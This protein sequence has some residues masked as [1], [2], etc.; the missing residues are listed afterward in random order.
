M[1]E[2]Q[3]KGV[4][5]LADAIGALRDELIRAWSSSQQQRLRFKPSPVQLTV[6]V[7]VTSAGKGRAGVRW[8]LVELGGEVSR[9]TVTTQTL[10][11]SLDPVMYDDQGRPHD[12]LISDVD[13]EADQLGEDDLLRDPE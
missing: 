9:E 8:W 6:Q 4:V 11:L 12:V 5:G 13:A 10:R 1:T 2:A 3:A 7:A